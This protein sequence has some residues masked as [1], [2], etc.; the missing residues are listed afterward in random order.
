MLTVIS[1]IIVLLMGVGSISLATFTS[2]VIRDRGAEQISWNSSHIT[3]HFQ[4][5]LNQISTLLYM[6]RAYMVNNTNVTQ[7]QWSGF[8]RNQ[9]IFGQFA[10]INSINFMQVVP[11]GQ[12]AAFVAQMQKRGANDYTVAPPGTRDQ[13]LLTS[14][15][16]SRNNLPLNGFDAYS[17]ADRRQVF[18]KALSTGTPTASPPLNLSTGPRSVFVT[19]PVVN[20]G[21]GSSFVTAVV[22]VND[23]FDAEAATL[24]L[25]PLLVRFTDVTDPKNPQVLYSSA[26]WD[27][28]RYDLTKSD[29]I[30][31]GGRQWRV[32][33]RS[34]YPYIQSVMQRLVPF[35]VVLAG[36]LLAV[37]FLLILYIFFRTEPKN[38]R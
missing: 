17:T 28:N 27:A 35:I 36:G 3:N 10:G 31:F 20:G 11:D 26:G 21:N 12:K 2:N 9:D 4:D 34:Q 29:A 1:A 33:Y 5:E 37:A 16:V 8:F 7:A 6:S 18:E 38:A 19:L 23:F 14:L 32:D 30:N 15:S 25:G 13:Y 24:N 22:Y